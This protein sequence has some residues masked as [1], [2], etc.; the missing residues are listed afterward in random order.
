M[1]YPEIIF[2]AQSNNPS[3]FLQKFRMLSKSILNKNTKK[4]R[5]I[6]LS[7]DSSEGIFPAANRRKAR[8]SKASGHLP[9]PVKTA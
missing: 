7:S 2:I 9:E 8:Y 5:P 1:S 4:C 6:H 3:P